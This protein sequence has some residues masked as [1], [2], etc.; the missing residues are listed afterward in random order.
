MVKLGKMITC[1]RCGE[2]VFLK[3]IDTKVTDGGYTKSDVY[4]SKPEN[5]GR[6]TERGRDLCPSCFGYYKE[7]VNDFYNTVYRKEMGAEEKNE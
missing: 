5:W 1:D 7:I 4:E 3:I 6:D 2:N